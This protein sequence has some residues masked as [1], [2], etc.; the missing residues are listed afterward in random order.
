MSAGTVLLLRHGQIVQAEPRRFV[1]QRELPLDDVG[2]AQA[3]EAG[4]W[5]AGL[6]LARVVSS[7]LGR[8]VETA[9]IILAHQSRS[10]AHPL[11]LTTEPGLREVSLGQWEG[12]TSAEVR[13]QFA[14]T[15][16]RRGEDPAWTRPEGGESYS[17]LWQRSA[18]V[19][20]E[21]VLGADDAAGPTLVVAHSAVN[22][23]LLCDLLGL[24]LE[25]AQDLGQD[26]CGL[27]V[28][29]RE[30]GALR[31]LSWNRPCAG[32]LL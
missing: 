19:F 2:R 31:V 8:A 5:L 9:S 23:V 11:T 24:P 20:Q 3:E 29:R 13:E 28:L 10:Q 21:I 1:G 18:A 22:R 30:E 17:D 14:E 26:Y 16:A 7:D 27:N 12:L 6:N 15:Y 32:P 25:K 4:R